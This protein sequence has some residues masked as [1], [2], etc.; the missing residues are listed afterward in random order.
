MLARAK[1]YYKYGMKLKEDAALET[2][3]FLKADLAAGSQE[4]LRRSVE[5]GIALTSNFPVSADGF[6][7]LSMAQVETLDFVAS[8]A[9][10]KTYSELSE[11]T[12]P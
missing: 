8:E 4:K 10:Y 11:G 6:L 7:W 3:E 12:M 5:I 9:N 2:D 1:T